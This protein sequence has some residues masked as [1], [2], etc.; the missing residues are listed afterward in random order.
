MCFSGDKDKEWQCG[1]GQP[2]GFANRA[3]SKPSL[4]RSF[5]LLLSFLFI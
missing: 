1:T 3:A 4:V 2:M 5:N